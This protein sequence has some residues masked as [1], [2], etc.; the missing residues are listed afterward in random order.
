MKLPLPQIDVNI[1]KLIQ[2]VREPSVDKQGYCSFFNDIITLCNKII[3]LYGK[4]I[5]GEETLNTGS[6]TAKQCWFLRI[7]M[8]K[9]LIKIKKTKCRLPLKIVQSFSQMLSMQVIF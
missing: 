6:M 9:K 8:G 7:I 1:F 4:N 2:T 5:K 3:T